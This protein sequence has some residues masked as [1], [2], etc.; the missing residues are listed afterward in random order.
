MISNETEKIK[1]VCL[2]TGVDDGEKLLVYAHELWDVET[3]TMLEFDC[4]HKE[5]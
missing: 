2:K 1:Y 4:T 3:Q 5:M